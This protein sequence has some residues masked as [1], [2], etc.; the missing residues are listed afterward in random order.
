MVNIVV[1][2]DEERIRKGLAKLITQAGREFHVTGIFAGAQELLAGIDAIS[3]DLVITDIKMPVMNGL[4]LIEKLQARYPGLKLAIISGFDDFIF[5][6]QA[7]RFGV[8]DYLLKPV[9]KAELAKM[10]YQV[11][12]KLEQEYA[13]IKENQDERLKLLLFNDAE[14]LPKHIRLEACRQLE[15]WP[16][17][18]DAYAVFV[19]RGNPRMSHEQMS[20]VTAAWLPKSVLLEWDERMI[21]IVGIHNSEHADRVREL[22]QTLLHRLPVNQEARIGGSDVFRGTTWL[23][24]AF[25]QGDQAMQQAWYDA[26]KRAFSDYARKSRKPHSIKHLLVLLDSEFQEEMALSDYVKA[27]EAVQRWFRQCIALMPGWNELREG[28]ETV[29]A[30]IGRYMPEQRNE[31]EERSVSCEPGHYGNKEIFSSYFLGEVDKLF[32]LL[33]QSRQENRVVE[34]VKQYIHQHFSEELE[35]NKLAEEV[36]LT[37]SYLSKLFKT[38]TG[39]TITDFLISVRIDRAKDWLRE[40]NALKTYEVGERVGYADP[41]YFNKVFKKVVGCTP[42]EFKDRVR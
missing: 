35:L 37:P 40:K 42:K 15:Q 16:L 8:Q 32:V 3:V 27:Q 6:R 30:L 41:A 18:Q 10:L 14:S 1:V 20:S 24:E 4:E 23:R 19:L 17:F 25:R 26:G 21:L 33:R 31:Q 5:A 29:L 7:L 11:R 28:C 9:D 34:T 36:Y 38:E 39:E 22:G 2:D 13:M 12:D